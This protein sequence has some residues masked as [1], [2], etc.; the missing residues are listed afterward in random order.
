MESAFDTVA[1]LAILAHSQDVKVLLVKN[2]K[3]WGFPRVKGNTTTSAVDAAAALKPLVYTA[4]LDETG[5]VNDHE[6]SR[7]YLYLSESAALYMPAEC[8]WE[9][10][11][12]AS[13]EEAFHIVGPTDESLL[14]W[15]ERTVKKALRDAL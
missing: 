3:E 11:R 5:I 13:F 7:A 10:V 15:T 12:Y 2:N 14:A 8:P 1:V 6:N 4:R 9:D